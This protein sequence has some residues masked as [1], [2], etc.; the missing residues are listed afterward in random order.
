MLDDLKL[1]SQAYMSE[2]RTARAR[3]YQGSPY[4]ITFVSEEPDH[5]TETPYAHSD[6]RRRADDH[7]FAPPPEDRFQPPSSIYPD[8]G[9]YQGGPGY[10][11]GSVYSSEPGYMPGSGFITSGPGQPSNFPAMADPR[12]YANPSYGL[13]AQPS[14]GNYPEQSYPY[15]T[16]PAYGEPAQPRSNGI[17]AEFLY[18]TTTSNV[19]GRPAPVDERYGREYYESQGPMQPPVGGRGSGGYGIPQR[20]QPT[21]Y[22]S[23]PSYERQ[24]PSRDPY[25]SRRRQ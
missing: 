9:L 20:G 13:Y 11:Q 8:N 12:N 23:A 4:R 7:G 16:G 21:P 14:A 1:A 15:S 6:T 3:G 10:P 22:E 19:A 25:S 18:S 2:N 5:V 24:D 17:P